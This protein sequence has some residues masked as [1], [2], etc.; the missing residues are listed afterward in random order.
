MSVRGAVW[1]CMTLLGSLAP[2]ARAEESASAEKQPVK[3]QVPADPPYMPREKGSVTFNIHI[4]PILFAN[5]TSCHRAGEVAPFS[6]TNYREAQKRDV[7]IAA[8]VKDRVMPPWKAEPGYGE[9]HDARRLTNEQI[10]MINQW[11]ED[12]S[13]EGNEKDLPEL[14]R[15]TDGWQLGPP[16]LIL[17]MPEAC[18]VPAEG[19]DVYR[20]FVLPIPIDEDKYV[21][22]VE[23]RPGNRR[24]VHHAIMFLDSSGAARKKDEADPGPGF[25]SFGGP[26]FIPSGGLGGW[27]PGAMPRPSPEGTAKL[28]KK[29]SDLALQVHFHPSGKEET[30]QSQI[31]LYFSKEPPKR[32]L[33]AITLRGRKLSIPAGDKAYKVTDAYTTAIDLEAVGIIPHAHLLAKDIRCN[34]T[35]P[36]GSVQPLIWIKDWD[37]AWQ[38]QYQY[39]RPVKLPKGTKIEME[40]TYDNSAENPR[41]PSNP[42]KRV[43]WGEQTTDEMALCWVQVMPSDESDAAALKLAAGRGIFGGGDGGNL[44]DVIK[45]AVKK[46]DEDGDGKL[47]EAERAKALEAW[48]KLREGK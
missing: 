35:L 31:G 40:F 30:E 27:A 47:N 2:V 13:P 1:C 22:A 3:V 10:G 37:F 25:K 16:D 18:T 21:R 20:C 14:P 34:A 38:G 17:K 9:F 7:Q 23:Y 6:I 39:A 41:N 46:Y 8:V 29:G 12:G 26:G 48:R 15:F 4:A 44:R 45:E 43:T 19:R 28:L 11:V 24:V 42:P 36:D 33:A 32:T 5:C